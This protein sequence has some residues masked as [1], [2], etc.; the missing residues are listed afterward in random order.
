MDE[1]N[2][3]IFADEEGKTSLEAALALLGGGFAG[4]QV[5]LRSDCARDVI[6][7]AGDDE[8][9][10]R[11]P[12]RLGQ[13]LAY[14]DVL[15]RRG[16]QREEAKIMIGDGYL[17]PVASVFHSGERSER[18]TEKEVEILQ[19]LHACNGAVIGRNELLDAVWGYAQGVETHTLETH[20][21]RLRQK[22]ERDP[23]APQI[24]LTVENGYCLGMV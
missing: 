8:R 1:H 11:A 24:L 21:Y 6:V 22:I 23:S 4:V 9:Q 15:R 20:I 10:F 18:L 17:D 12:V 16:R 5:K 7:A 13:V 2:P 19:A 14:I 3:I